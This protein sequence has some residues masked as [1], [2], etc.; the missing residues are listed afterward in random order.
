MLLTEDELIDA[1]PQRF[2]L[3]DPDVV[4]LLLTGS[5]VDVAEGR[6]SLEQQKRFIAVVK[7]EEQPQEHL[8]K[9]EL[10]QQAKALKSPAERT[11]L[12]WRSALDDFLA[13]AAVTY[14]TSA[15][16]QHAIFISP[17]YRH[18][19][20]HQLLGLASPFCV[21]SGSFFVS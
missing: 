12:G 4:E 2:D 19:S 3:S 7:G 9:E 6:I 8:S 1:V 15:I 5:D 10:I 17:G 16:R 11:V 14:P 18:A 20:G 13:H 21:V